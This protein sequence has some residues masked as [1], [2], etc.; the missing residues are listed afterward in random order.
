MGT[1][2]CRRNS[3]TRHR[4]FM[5]PGYHLVDNMA[6][7]GV[8]LSVRHLTTEPVCYECDP[9]SP[10]STDQSEGI[11]RCQ[12]LTCPTLSS[13]SSPDYPPFY[14]TR[15]KDYHPS[16][17]SM[18]SSCRPSP[19][20]PGLHDGP[21]SRRGPWPDA[22]PACQISPPASNTTT[23]NR[24][25]ATQM[26]CLGGQ[27]KTS[28]TVSCPTTAM[29]FAV[30]RESLTTKWLG[31]LAPTTL[32]NGHIA[33]CSPSAQRVPRFLIFPP[34]PRRGAGLPSGP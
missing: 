17:S 26:A 22:F 9:P 18:R 20:I 2:F 4:V 28:W 23:V 21:I 27:A 19:Q 12:V 24:S 15:H 5:L 25:L 14:L 33:I 31:P 1:C 29:R 13:T 6:D 30:S 3:T 7:A 8:P 10:S 32:T 34:A 16:P 11:R